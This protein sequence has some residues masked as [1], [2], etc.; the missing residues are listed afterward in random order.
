MSTTFRMPPLPTEI[1]SFAFLR[2]TPRPPMPDRHEH[3]ATRSAYWERVVA[4]H[5]ALIAVTALTAVY[6]L[7]LFELDSVPDTAFVRQKALIARAE[8]AFPW[9]AVETLTGC[10]ADVES[11]LIPG[12]SPSRAPHGEYLPAYGSAPWSEWRTAA[13]ATHVPLVTVVPVRLFHE[14]HGRIDVKTV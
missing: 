5:S 8:A 7:A 3:R 13:E 2:R 10:I 11:R 12:Q 9:D 1:A 4:G 14:Q 6:E